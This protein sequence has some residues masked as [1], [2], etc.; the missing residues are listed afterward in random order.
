MIQ[1]ERT[2][3]FPIHLMMLT[4]HQ[5]ETMTLQEDYNSH[6]QH[7]NSQQTDSKLNAAICKRTI[8]YGI[9]VWGQ[10]GFITEAFKVFFFFLKKAIDVI[11]HIH[12]IKLKN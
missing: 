10:M 3:D 9:Y 2:K 7:K 4:Q 6:E 5:T 1:R 8:H 12:R 11:N